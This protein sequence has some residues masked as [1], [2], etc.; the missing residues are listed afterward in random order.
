MR[1]RVNVNWTALVNK[2]V[3]VE[4]ESR[5]EALEIVLSRCADHV[6][7]KNSPSDKSTMEVVDGDGLI[8]PKNP[9][10]VEYYL[11]EE[12]CGVIQ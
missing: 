2:V 8:L 9:D 4:A 5:E 12:L 10:S 1:F 6:E 3:E 7:Y 11:E